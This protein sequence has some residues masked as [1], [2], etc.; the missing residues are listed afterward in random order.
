MNHKKNSLPSET[1]LTEEARRI[2]DNYVPVLPADHWAVIGDFV[3]ECVR[4][5][6]PSRAAVTRDYLCA[7]ANLARWAWQTVGLDLNTADVFG[8][9]VVNRFVDETMAGNSASYRHETARRLQLMV[10]HF[11]GLPPEQARISRL[12]SVRPY[13]DRE[14]TTFRS[15]A[16]RRT[17]LKRRVNAHVLLGL[18]AGAGLR[19][20]EIAA[21]RVGDVT[22]D[23][24]GL[25]VEVRG[26]HERTVPVRGEWVRTLTRGVQN[27]VPDEFAFIGYRMPEYPG[28]VVHRLIVQA[29]A[30]D[31][32]NATRL[33]TTWLM[34]QLNNGIPLSVL[35]EV[36]GLSSPASLAPYMP[37]VAGRNVLDF[38]H[39]LTGRG[40][41]R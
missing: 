37:H 38:R 32:P 10:A 6:A 39:A 16:A 22:G 20:T 27:R 3:R 1:P 12:N 15:S 2:I 31:T 18:G 11:T 4:A 5:C 34:A 17:T 13:S 26:K 7:A 41:N 9:H 33:R 19:L 30:E 23:D 8:R 36:A 25:L 35:L 21:V 14:L 24:E 28:R 40:A 29:P